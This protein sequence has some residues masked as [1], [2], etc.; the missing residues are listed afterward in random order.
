MDAEAAPGPDPVVS[1]GR[2]AWSVGPAEDSDLQGACRA[3]RLLVEE[4][5]SQPPDPGASLDAARALLEDPD[6]GLLIVARSGREI[7]GVLAVSWQT[8]IHVPGRYALIQD[9][10]VAPSWRGR[11]VGRELIVA[12]CAEAAKR[13]IGRVEVGLP[14]PRFAAL[15][16]TESFYARNGFCTVGPRMR[17][18]VG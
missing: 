6:A 14:P 16:A 15:A 3:V 18:L 13:S 17:R 9:L 11:R 2:E 12:I 10:W 5:G 7:V 1:A 4:L 8:A